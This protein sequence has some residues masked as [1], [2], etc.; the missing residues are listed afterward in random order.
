MRVY[1]S[2]HAGDVEYSLAKVSR[3]FTVAL[4]LGCR[5]IRTDVY[6]KDLEPSPGR[7]D[8]GKAEFYRRYWEMACDA[9]LEP[10]P[11]LSGAPDWAKTLLKNNGSAT[12]LEAAE[13]YAASAM[14]LLPTTCRA[15]GELHVQ[16]WNELNH[17]PS[18]WVRSQVWSEPPY[19][20][21]T[22]TRSDS[23]RRCGTTCS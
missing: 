5:G 23:S 8:S 1:C 2:L 21:T 17:L 10:F 19:H 18:L 12:F 20:V 15:G 6:W 7:G 14:P 9:G 3:V 13:A 16:L 22:S 4:T 11:I